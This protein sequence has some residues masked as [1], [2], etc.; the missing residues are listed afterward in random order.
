MYES[1]NMAKGD[2]KERK[3]SRKLSSKPVH[4][5]ALKRVANQY[6]N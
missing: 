1:K 2:Q 4:H 5:N 3:K 6:F